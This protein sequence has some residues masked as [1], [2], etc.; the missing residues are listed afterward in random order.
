MR[1]GGDLFQVG[2]TDPAGMDADEEFSGADHGNGDRFQANVVH[3][4]IN[5]G[6]HGCGDRARVSLDR[7]RSD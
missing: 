5:G 4:A 7:R 6:L 3:T 2:A 1:A